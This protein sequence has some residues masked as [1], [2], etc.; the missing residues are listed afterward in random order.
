MAANL[1]V[2]VKQQ[3]NLPAVFGL[4]YWI[5]VHI[6]KGQ[7]VPPPCKQGADLGCQL[8]AERAAFPRIERER[9]THPKSSTGCRASRRRDAPGSLRSC[10][11]ESRRWPCDKL[12]RW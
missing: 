5:G 10:R 12:P 7:G 2:A 1:G 8:L 9:P 6:H 4:E 3:R 11:Q